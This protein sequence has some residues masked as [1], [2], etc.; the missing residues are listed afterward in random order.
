[1]LSKQELAR[2]NELAKLA[3]TTGLTAEEAKEQKELR[4]AYLQTFRKS[5]TN[6][7]HQVTVVDE[8]GNDVT[9]D[10]LKESKKRKNERFH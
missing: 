2:I 6:Q 9:P 3:K 1:M 10:T 8:N 4:E 5:F 7:L